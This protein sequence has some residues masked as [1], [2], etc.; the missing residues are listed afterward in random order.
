MVCGA[1]ARESRS[2]CKKSNQV[3]A[4]RSSSGYLQLAPGVRPHLLVDRDAPLSEFGRIAA[5][6]STF[7]SSQRELEMSQRTADVESQRLRALQ[8]ANDV[9]RSRADLKRHI[10]AGDLSAAD[11]LLAPPAAAWGCAVREI[12]LSQRGWGRVKCTRFLAKNDIPEQKTIR[13]LT[14]RQ[15]LQL[16]AELRRQ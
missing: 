6:H 11:C 15:R 14:E 4:R 3:P 8:L 9:R 10:A 12:L 2:D 7:A 5:S 1:Q 16:A 13:D